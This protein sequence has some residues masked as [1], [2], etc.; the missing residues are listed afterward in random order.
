MSLLG[1]ILELFARI[2]SPL[3]HRL[4]LPPFRG[5]DRAFA[6]ASRFLREVAGPGG[7]LLVIGGIRDT[8]RAHFLPH[9]R[10][11]IVDL[12]PGTGVSVRCD[13]H[14]L[15][16]RD[17]SMDAAM[18]QGVLNHVTEAR[19]V[20]AEVWRVVRPGGALYANTAFLLAHHPAPIDRIRFTGEGWKHLLEGWEIHNLAASAGP[21]GAIY[22]LTLHIL[23]HAVRPRHLRFMAWFLAG[24]LLRPLWWLDR[25]ALRHP[26][27][28]EGA[29]A[30]YVLATRP[31]EAK[32]R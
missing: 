15:P 31:G 27:S 14:R 13:A 25:L 29:A 4:P 1:Q 30:I 2:L 11:V 5:V 20:L 24:H 9:F 28:I 12:V 18:A 32:P 17:A 21:L 22:L 7:T 23:Q 10:P 19:R 26:W 6:P 16:F 8:D 3:L